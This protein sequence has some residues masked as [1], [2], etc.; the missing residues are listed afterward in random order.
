MAVDT[1]SPPEP[2]RLGRAWSDLPLRRK[3]VVVVAIPLVA[4]VV[5]GGSFLLVQHSSGRA[6]RELHA[7]L[8][9]R[10][11]ILEVRALLVDAETGVR[12]YLLVGRDAFLT[13][14]FTARERLPGALG[15]LGSMV[16]DE[17]EQADR[18]ARVAQMSERRLDILD[19]L[20][21][22][23]P[24]GGAPTVEQTQALAQGRL[25]AQSVRG[26]LEQM[27]EHEAG[28][29]AEQLVRAEG[30]RRYAF[31]V[32]VLCLLLGL[33]GGIV[34]ALLFSSG[35]VDRV[36]RVEASARRLAAGE[37]PLV[38]RDDRDELG[39]LSRAI[40]RTGIRLREREHELREA[41]EFLESLVAA[42]PAV[43][44]QMSPDTLRIKYLSP[45][46]ERILGYTTEEMTGSSA[47]VLERI[48]PDDRPDV[49]RVL[50]DLIAA[51]GGQAE[52]E[53]RFR[54]A[55]GTYLW[56]HSPVH[57]QGQEGEWMLVGHVLDISDR[58]EM[59][60]LKDEFVS[61]VSHELRTPLTSIRGALGLLASGAIGELSERGQRM[62]DI[63]VHNT[64][65]L[66][67]LINDI[68]DIERMES[69]R[70]EMDPRDHDVRD[71]MEQGADVMQAMADEHTVT[72][73]V[74]PVEAP[75]HADAD[76]VLQT[77]TNLLS[78]AIKFSEPGGA[79]HLEAEQNGGQVLFRVRDEG[80][81]IPPSKIP[82]IFERFTQ[83]DASDSREKG[84]TGLG[85][86][87]CKKI[88]ERHG[89]RIWLDSEVGRGT[90]VSFT[91]PTQRGRPLR[92]RGEILVCDDDTDVRDRLIA[93][94]GS[95]GFH[96]TAVGSGMEA[97]QMARER[98]PD[99]ILLDLVMPGQ[100]GWE[101]LEELKED[102]AT[103]DVPVVILSHVRPEDV[104]RPMEAVD[105]IVKPWDP[106]VVQRVVERLVGPTA[107]DTTALIVEDDTDLAEVLSEFLRGAGVQAVC[108]AT[109]RDA[110]ELIERLDPDL[111][112]L[113]LVLFEGSGFE[114]VDRLRARGRIGAIPIIVYSGKDLGAGERARLQL[115]RTEFMTKG[116]TTPE[117]LQRRIL[118]LVGTIVGSGTEEKQRPGGEA[119]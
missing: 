117:E 1:H 54:H 94:I 110:V 28:R 3:G 72:L 85:L 118:D 8:E 36:G 17:A 55:D 50:G 75:V 24:T 60:R 47:F 30:V 12:G 95:R 57:L 20:R 87:I 41:K 88:V 76:R 70:V 112:V 69:G 11:Q 115:G 109:T 66:I 113:D 49:E 84:G 15:R 56:V 18:A 64:D 68:L 42:S 89:G 96:V 116:R 111:L 97:L 100:N 9:L 16:Q 19:T 51:G 86:A 4:L 81:G 83:V 107:R 21:R 93:D 22:T 80:R 99:V 71:L 26:I 119:T 52:V 61:V 27:E 25:V 79:V 39:E 90:T 65:R 38:A 106:E 73:R 40:E 101:V 37:P 32:V 74:L 45:N 35:V 63:A 58:R 10:S 53:Y 31:L 92:G 29:L 6:D 103:R 5:A 23:R 114:V 104:T 2:S 59:Q 82:T 48:H 91:L 77:I 33:V 67:R 14:Y 13:P 78:N 98:R 105:W 102:E 44:F 34:A 43:V 108:A 7:T 62:L 46:V